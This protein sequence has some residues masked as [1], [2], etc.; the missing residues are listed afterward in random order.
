MTSRGFTTRQAIG[1][2]AATGR[3][4][5]LGTVLIAGTLLA[6]AMYGI[7]LTAR[8]LSTEGPSAITRSLVPPLAIGLMA[9]IAAIGSMLGTSV[10]AAEIE[11]GTAQFGWSMMGR[12]SWL[13]LRAVP[14][15]TVAAGSIMPVAIALGVLAGLRHPGMSAADDYGLAGVLPILRVL[16]VF[17]CAT[18]IGL[19]TGRSMAALVMSF[20]IGIACMAILFLA[21][22][23]G[24]TPSA[25]TGDSPNGSR[26][27]ATLYRTA[28]GRLL[29]LRAAE[30][31]GAAHRRRRLDGR[32]DGRGVYDRQ[33]RHHARPDPGGDDPGVC[34]DPGGHR[35]TRSGVRRGRR[36]AAAK[37]RRI[38]R[39]VALLLG[40]V[41]CAASLSSGITAQ[42][43]SGTTTSDPWTPPGRLPGSCRAA[44]DPQVA[45]TA[46]DRLD[47]LSEGSPL[48]GLGLATLSPDEIEVVLLILRLC[49]TYRFVYYFPDGSGDGYGESWCTV[50]PGTVGWISYAPDGSLVVFVVA[51]EAM[52]VRPQ[53]AGGWW[54]CDDFGIAAPSRSTDPS[55]SQALAP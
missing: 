5:L 12:R 49:H 43:P 10:A 48:A 24:T 9:G 21:W 29:D 17:S 44:I 11:R 42:A 36:A 16:L 25:F 40:C 14:A 53:P 52:A 35:G 13:V 27:I 20:A 6:V 31:P 23:F 28:D 15:A 41:S 26:V 33:P 37:L 3:A 8:T 47:P 38:S 22:P 39:F 50:P 55:P 19:I 34:A 18:L 51:P 54:Y 32:V 45:G 2:L 7:T 30:D 4:E 1:L 46:L